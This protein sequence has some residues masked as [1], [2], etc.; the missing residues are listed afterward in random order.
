MLNVNQELPPMQEPFNRF[1]VPV[2]DQ[3]ATPPPPSLPV[4]QAG[5]IIF[6]I[7]V[8]RSANNEMKASIG[9]CTAPPWVDKDVFKWVIENV[10]THL[11]ARTE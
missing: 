6:C 7:G 4:I 11:H 3:L 5:E 9:C 8:T 1:D 2:K 10:G